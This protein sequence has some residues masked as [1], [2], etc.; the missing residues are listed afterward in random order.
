MIRRRQAMTMA[1]A[2]AAG[3]FAG[4]R[5]VQAQAK[6][7]IIVGMSQEITRFHPLALIS[8]VDQGIH[9]HLYNPL[10]LADPDGLKPSLAAEIPSVENGGLSA[11]GLVWKIKLR[12]DVKWHDGKPFTAEDVKFTIELILNKD[13]RSLG[14]SGYDLIR[15]MTVVSPTEITWRLERP[16][17]PFMAIMSW[18]FIV[19]KHLLDGQPDPNAGPF[20]SAPVGTGPFKFVERVPGNYLITDANPDYFAQ[21]AKVDRVIYR[22]IPDQTVLY[23]QFRTG[24]VDYTSIPGISPDKFADAGKLPDRTVNLGARPQ[25]ETITLNVGKPQ[26]AEK[27]VRQAL[28]YGIDKKSLMEAVYYNTRPEALSYLPPESWAYNPG[29]EKHEYSLDKAKALLDEAG[30]KPGADG[31]R[32]KNGV[33]LEFVNATTSGNPSRE[34]V[35]QVLIQSWGAIGAKMTIN[36]MPLAIVFGEYYQMSKFDSVLVGTNYMVGPDPDVSVKFA[37]TAI[38]A[39][40]GS[41]QNYAQFKNEALDAVLK[42]A[43]QIFDQAKR[44]ELY[45]KAQE[46]MRDELPILPLYQS[47][48]IEGTKAKLKGFRPNIYSRTGSWN[49]WEWY[50]QA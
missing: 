6:S 49:L 17:A 18:T 26:F 44:K 7:Q 2:I 25:I 15:D 45:F 14:R 33:R 46:I 24:E 4:G 34:L 3:T 38:P 5:V 37:S 23:T 40:G 36:N 27:A 19:P 50:W 47:S 12:D 28:Y 31:V 42:E 16:S 22:Y 10:W 48:S 8:D 43:A 21:K 20:Y 39:Q 11:D 32:E 9:W 30:W 29:L 13:F 1:A 35:Q 41:G